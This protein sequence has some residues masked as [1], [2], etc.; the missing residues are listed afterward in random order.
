MEISGTS[1]SPPPPPLL[2]S[3]T[4]QGFKEGKEKTARPGPVVDHTRAVC[5]VSIFF[6]GEEDDL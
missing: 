6:L 2:K 1:S 5:S 3:K 4:W